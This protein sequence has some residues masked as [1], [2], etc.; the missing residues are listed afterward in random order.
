MDCPSTPEMNAAHCRRAKASVLFTTPSADD[1]PTSLVLGA[2]GESRR[3]AIGPLLAAPKLVWA[4][5]AT[6]VQTVLDGGQRQLASAQARASADQA[7]SAYRQG[8]LTALQEVED[9]LSLAMH[10]QQEVQ[11]QVDA[12]EAARR[13]LAITL[14]Q[15]HAGTASYLNVVTAQTA[16]LSAES[17]VLVLRNRQ[18]AAVN[19]LLKNIAGRWNPA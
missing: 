6:L 1:P 18:L 9:N 5:G 12:L 2:S 13:T 14:V 4:L 10:L 15:Y 19:L 3:G 17:S 16:A 7:T 11:L 8:V